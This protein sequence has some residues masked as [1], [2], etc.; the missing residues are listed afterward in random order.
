MLAGFA[1]LL[2]PGYHRADDPPSFRRRRRHRARGR[3][4]AGGRTRGL[5][6]RN[7]LRPR[8]RRDERARGRRHLRRQ[9]PAAFQPADLPL[10]G[11]RGRLPP[12]RGERARQA[13]RRGLL[14][15]RAD[16]GAAA[17][18]RLPGIP[19]RRRRA[20]NAGRAG[21]RQ[22]HGAGLVAR[23]RPAG[24]R[25]L[26]QPFG[27]G[28]PQHRRA[29]AGGARRAHRRHP[30][31]RPLPDRRGIDRA[32]PDRSAPG[33][34]A[35]RRRDRGGDRGIGRSD[36]P[37]DPARGGRGGTGAALAGT[38]GLALC[39]KPAGPAQRRRGGGRRGAAGVRPALA[40]GWLCVQSQRKPGPDRSRRP[41]VHR[42]ALAGQAGPGFGIEGYRRHERARHR[43][44]PGDQRPPAARRSAERSTKGS[45]QEIS[46]RRE[47]P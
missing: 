47:S 7:R 42:A 10:P 16:P 23:G 25:A 30:G 21:A 27:A 39:A 3:P 38:A 14:A 11:R 12:C 45:T 17:P 40:G 34:A 33:A 5:R 4:A 2:P 8:R 41:P 37:A 31:Q 24:G 13:P 43:A 9:G 35:S 15:G 28:Q 19:A 29:C 22:R 1:M 26:R 18:H 20:G 6:H 36:R 46:Q 32:R 44:R